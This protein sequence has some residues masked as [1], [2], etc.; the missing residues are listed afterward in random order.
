MF[1]GSYQEA[2]GTGC[3]TRRSYLQPRLG[4]NTTLGGSGREDIGETVLLADHLQKPE[5]MRPWL[6]GYHHMSESSATK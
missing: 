5:R 1:Q 6:N 3:A 4:F 2:A